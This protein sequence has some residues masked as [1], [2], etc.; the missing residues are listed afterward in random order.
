MVTQSSSSPSSLVRGDDGCYGQK[1]TM[2]PKPRRVEVVDVFGVAVI[3]LALPPEV[4]F[5]ADSI[6]L[7]R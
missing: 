7:L 2:P 6:L 4:A 3:N 1:L 5:K